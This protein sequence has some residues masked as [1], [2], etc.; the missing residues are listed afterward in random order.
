LYQT[1]LWTFGFL[2]PPGLAWW[3][4]VFLP[5]GVV[6][7]WI[8]GTVPELARASVPQLAPRAHI[9]S[10]HLHESAQDGEVKLEITLSGVLCW[11]ALL[12][13]RR[14]STFRLL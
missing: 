13:S 4:S 8:S 6:A 14:F 2:H 7:A 9:F 3:I 11:V 10:S 5:A 12:V 1:E